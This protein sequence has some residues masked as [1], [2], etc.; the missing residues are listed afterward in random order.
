MWDK[1]EI[2][3]Y[4]GKIIN[5]IVC[6]VF[7]GLSLKCFNNW[8]TILKNRKIFVNK[9][10][11]RLILFKARKFSRE[12]IVSLGREAIR[13]ESTKQILKEPC[14]LPD[15]KS[16]DKSTISCNITK[17]RLYENRSLREFIQIMKLRYNLK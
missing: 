2:Q 8:N 3:Y 10:D 6:G 11:L 15:G 13:C 17:E 1:D 5:S 16:Y 9:K 12:Y 4:I 14:V 7:I